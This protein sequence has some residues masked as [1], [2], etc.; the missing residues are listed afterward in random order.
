[1]AARHTHAHANMPGPAQQMCAQPASR[2][3]SELRPSS[4]ARETG[5]AEGRACSARVLSS[6]RVGSDEKRSRSGRGRLS[7]PL[8]EGGAAC[9]HASSVVAGAR[10]APREAA[11]PPRGTPLSRLLVAGSRLRLLVVVGDLI[12]VRERRKEQAP[13]V[14][15]CVPYTGIGASVSAS[16]VRGDAILLAPPCPRAA[17]R[18]AAFGALVEFETRSQLLAE[19]VAAHRGNAAQF[20]FAASVVVAGVNVAVGARAEGVVACGRADTARLV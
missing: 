14:T 4:C 18:A 19:V 16:P 6:A 15:R 5:E 3:P 12:L 9:A 11:P 1:M 10:V 2:D 13:A 8:P 20:A 17:P 7:L